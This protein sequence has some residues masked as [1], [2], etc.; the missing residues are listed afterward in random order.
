M[1]AF[2]IASGRLMRSSALDGG[3]RVILRSPLERTP[4][5]ATHPR[6]RTVGS[7]P[8][9]VGVRVTGRAGLAGQGLC[10]K[11]LIGLP[12]KPSRQSAV[13]LTLRT[14]NFQPDVHVYPPSRPAIRFYGNSPPLS[15][16]VAQTVQDFR[17]HFTRNLGKGLFHGRRQACSQ[18]KLRASHDKEQHF[19]RN[20][21]QRVR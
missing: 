3:Y 6:D 15:A 4:T 20:P 1:V 16:G 2:S 17:L 19:A 8:Q 5:T 13:N 9:G 12:A 21:A 18:P 10:L 7:R 11:P 14:P